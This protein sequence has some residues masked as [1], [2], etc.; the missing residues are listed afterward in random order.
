MFYAFPLP[1]TR[2]GRPGLVRLTSYLVLAD[3]RHYA[4]TLA[5][6]MT[7]FHEEVVRLGGDG[8]PFAEMDFDPA[9]AIVIGALAQKRNPGVSVDAFYRIVQAPV[10]P[11]EAEL[12]FL[13]PRFAGP[14][15]DGHP[16]PERAGR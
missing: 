3:V 9:E 4:L 14:H 2:R 1:R 7:G 15:L 8:L 5:A 13:S 12:I 6:L 16:V 10:R 11:A